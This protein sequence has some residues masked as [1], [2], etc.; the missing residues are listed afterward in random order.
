MATGCGVGI[1]MDSS[2]SFTVCGTA[3]F[4]GIQY[5]NDYCANFTCLSI[6]HA[7]WVTGQTGGGGTVT[8]ATNLG[9]GNGTLYTSLSGKDLQFKTISGGT[10]IGLTTNANYVGINFTG[11]TGGGFLG[12]VTKDTSEPPDLAQN[13]WVKPEPMSTDCFAYTFDNFLDSGSTAISVNLSLEDVYLRYDEDNTAWIKE[14]Y[15]KPLSSGYTWV[16]G[17]TCKAE[18]VAVINEWVNTPAEVC[19]VGQKYAYQT[20]TQIFAQRQ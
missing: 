9:S 20:Q 14:S 15:E 5:D 16:G 2:P 19:Y 3:S 12:T 8:G 4:A 18:E 1:C 6:P 10:D 11:N 13:Q 7:G 17:D